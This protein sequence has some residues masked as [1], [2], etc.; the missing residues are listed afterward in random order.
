MGVVEVVVGDLATEERAGLDGEAVVQARPHPGVVGLCPQVVGG[1]E[2][3]RDREARRALDVHVD[4]IGPEEPREHLGDRRRDRR[5]RRWV[6]GVV[7]RHHERT[8]AGLPTVSGL[9]SSKPGTG[10]KPSFVTELGSI[11]ET[12][13]Q[14]R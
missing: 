10:P 7:R 3:S 9:P 6:L 2:I 13:R 11:A 8:P 12:G 5:V 14:F 1:R 4:L